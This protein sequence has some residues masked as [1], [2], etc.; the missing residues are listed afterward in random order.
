MLEYLDLKDG[1]VLHTVTSAE[2]GVSEAGY[3]HGTNTTVVVRCAYI[4]HNKCLDSM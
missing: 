4:P 1:T 2:G 3:A